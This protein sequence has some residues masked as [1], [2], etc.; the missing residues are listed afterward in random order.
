MKRFKPVTIKMDEESLGDLD[1]LVDAEKR[2]N[3]GYTVSIAA[4][5]RKLIHE[6]ARKMPRDLSHTQA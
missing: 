3:P 5:I 6:K 2:K 1:R 4:V